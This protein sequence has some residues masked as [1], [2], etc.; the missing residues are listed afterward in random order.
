MSGDFLK[1]LFH[2]LHR[3]RW[4][5][6][7]CK[8]YLCPAQQRA[9]GRK[10]KNQSPEV[11]LPNFTSGLSIKES[12]RL[13]ATHLSLAFFFLFLSFSLMNNGPVFKLYRLDTSAL[14]G[15][16]E[17]KTANQRQARRKRVV[18]FTEN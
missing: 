8:D 1:R 3:L 12:E 11:L 5:K 17:K 2:C 15:R 13:Q 7:L 16:K 18:C 6:D 9:G 10:K 14:G 4:A